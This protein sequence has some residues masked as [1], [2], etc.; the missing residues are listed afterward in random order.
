MTGPNFQPVPTET[1]MLDVAN[2]AFDRVF[3]NHDQFEL[4]NTADAL[5]LAHEQVRYSTPYGDSKIDVRITRPSVDSAEILALADGTIDEKPKAEVWVQAPRAFLFNLANG[6]KY[7]ADKGF[8]R[9]VVLSDGSYLDIFSVAFATN[10]N[11]QGD[12]RTYPDTV[13]SMLR[14]LPSETDWIIQDLIN[15]S[16]V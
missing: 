12:V 11:E 8:F 10:T 7:F 1:T 3:D 2:S 13:G 15:P 9:V 4:S 16:K 14:P 5:G 6:E